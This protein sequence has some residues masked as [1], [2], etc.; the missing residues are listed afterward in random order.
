MPYHQSSVPDL[1]L[2]NVFFVSVL[3]KINKI[4]VL[5]SLKTINGKY[6]H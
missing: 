5:L 4:Q 1:Y 6:I 2:L 3:N